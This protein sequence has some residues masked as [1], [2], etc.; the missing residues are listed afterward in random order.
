[1]HMSILLCHN[2][3]ELLNIGF[4]YWGQLENLYPPEEIDT[5]LPSLQHVAT[6][7]VL[8]RSNE[9]KFC[10]QQPHER[11]PEGPICLDREFPSG[12]CF[13]VEKFGYCS[14]TEL[15]GNPRFLHSWGFGNRESS[16]GLPDE[17]FPIDHE[18]MGG[19]FDRLR[20]AGVP[21]RRVNIEM[22]TQRSLWDSLYVKQMVPKMSTNSIPHIRS[23]ITFFRR[24]FLLQ[25][26]SVGL[27]R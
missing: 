9:T 25:S 14:L 16:F 22:T 6:A 26:V 23:K 10:M 7:C 5:I 8:I 21:F 1:M 4:F 15:Y 19:F 2:F 3:L 12:L 24:T 18:G 11:M 13:L 17:C 27:Q 20:L